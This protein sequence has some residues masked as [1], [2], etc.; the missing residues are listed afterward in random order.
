MK[1]AV[2]IKST[3]ADETLTLAKSLLSRASVNNELVLKIE[4]Q[5]PEL[6]PI[7]RRY[8]PPDPRIVESIPDADWLFNIPDVSM[9]VVPENWDIVDEIAANFVQF[10][11]APQTLDDLVEPSYIDIAKESIQDS[12]MDIKVDPQQFA[13]ESEPDFDTEYEAQFKEEDDGGYEIISTSQI[14]GSTDVI[15]VLRKKSN[16]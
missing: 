10:D 15:A 7:I 14:P 3:R 11:P 1:L 5:T 16:G 4:Y 2:I 8:L 12:A 9:P 6:E 13:T